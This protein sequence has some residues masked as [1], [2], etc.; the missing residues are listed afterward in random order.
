MVGIPGAPST[1]LTMQQVA[2]THGSDGNS[3][4]KSNKPKLLILYGSNSGTC[5]ALAEDLQTNANSRAGYEATVETM[6]R[7]TEHLPLDGTPVVI[8]TP[9]Y[10]G[11]PAD[12]ARKFVTWL[13]MSTSQ[14]KTNL[15]GLKYAVYGAGNSE[16]TNTFHRIPKLVDELCSKLGGTRICPAGLVDVK[17]D[18][19]GPWEDF[20]ANLWPSL[21]KATGTEHKLEEEIIKVKIEKPEYAKKLAGEEIDQGYVKKNEIIATDECGPAKK[22]MEVELPAGTTYQTGKIYDFGV[23]L[24]CTNNFIGDYLVVLPINPSDEVKRVCMKFKLN[25]D[26]AISITGT[27]KSFLVS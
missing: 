17:E 10:E 27:S 2:P 21:S 16:W 5:K 12:N 13:E 18:I 20:M 14:G 8:V 7:A 4:A 1:A 26:D 23:I 22:H 15:Q 25:V 24:N 19:V 11:K 3:E 9:S 6:D